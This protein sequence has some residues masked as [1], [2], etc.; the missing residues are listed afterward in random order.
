MIDRIGDM[1]RTEK[2]VAGNNGVPTEKAPV[3]V[4]PRWRAWL[5]LVRP[6]N[7][8]T[9][10]GDP[11]AGAALAAVGGAG[12]DVVAVGVAIVVA[13]CLYAAGLLLN[14][15]ADAKQ[16]AAER[17]D[18]PIPSGRVGRNT[19]RGAAVALLVLGVLIAWPLGRA[20]GVTAAV[21]GLLVVAYDGVTHRL[22]LT[23]FVNMGLCRATSL[24]LGAVACG[25]RPGGVDAVR[26]GSTLV[27][28]YI[29][30]VTAVAH[31]E[32]EQRRLGWVRVVPLAAVVL[33]G[34]WLASIV[35][36]PLPFAL[37]M[38]MVT[39]RVMHRVVVL[40]GRAAPRRVQASIGSLVR[41]LTL[42]QAAF[43]LLWLP[44]GFAW[45]LVPVGLFMLSSA[46]GRVFDAS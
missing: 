42:L 23:G 16:D 30:G 35:P 8:P 39:V 19:V 25:W 34:A 12:F 37:L 2:R 32:T 45:A 6:P 44:A 28:V 15:W 1:Q 14:D 11:L 13:V 41:T 36:T 5:E 26:I 3:G 20:V 24:L 38:A 29:A 4:T 21:L 17:P 31:H 40:S 22:R 46:L 7:L 33:G 10:P 43:C 27:L 9:V 18:R